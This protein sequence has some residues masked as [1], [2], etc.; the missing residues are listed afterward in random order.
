MVVNDNYSI[1]LSI[2]TTIHIG[3]NV[4]GN[5]DKAGLVD[6]R[7]PAVPRGAAL[8]TKPGCASGLRTVSAGGG[9]ARRNRP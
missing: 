8:G 6:A 9:S 7:R 3:E 4:M 2:E 5:E 1:D